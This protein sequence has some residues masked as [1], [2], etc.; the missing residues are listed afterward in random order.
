MSSHPNVYSADHSSAV[1]RTH[2]W[3]TVS[4]SA[5][6]LIPYLQPN[7]SILDVGC[8]PGSITVDFAQRVPQ[9]RVIGIEYSGVPLCTARAMAADKGVANIDFQGGD[10]HALPFA[11]NTFDVVHA[12]QV[13]Q[14]VA[15]PILAFQEMRRVAKTGGGIVAVRESVVPTWYPESPGLTKFWSVQEH[16]A[17]VK[18]G[19]PHCGKYLH[20]WAREAGFERSQITCSTGSWCFSTPEER[21][22]WGGSI[23]ERILSSSFATNALEMNLATKDD[24][25]MLSKAWRD[26]IDDENGWFS[27]LHG[28]V[29]C[30]K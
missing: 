28:E 20:V 9:G 21:A 3:R 12:H 15:D 5:A 6:Y 27:F 26:W 18:G 23:K 8:G 1:L 7:M 22:Y 19:N 24:L 16:M 11:D 4:N 30:R 29:I 14:H 10:I 25:N 17:S 2:G 13:L